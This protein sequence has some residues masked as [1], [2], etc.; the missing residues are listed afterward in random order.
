[1][2][3]SPKFLF[4]NKYA[5]PVSIKI[6]KMNWLS[7]DLKEKLYDLRNNK[8]DL[9][10]SEIFNVE[11]KLVISSDKRLK[12]IV[13]FISKTSKNS[14]VLFQSVGEGYGK[15]IYDMLREIQTE[16][17]IFYV[18]GDTG[19]FTREK[20]RRVQTRF[21]LLVL[22]LLVLVSLLKTSTIYF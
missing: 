2:E 6:V 11:R 17:E 10:G 5:T 13:D 12:Y 7:D 8:Q 20:W 14:L 1:M 4:D 21:L 9:E 16:K 22:E 15:R 3:I 19:T 18:D